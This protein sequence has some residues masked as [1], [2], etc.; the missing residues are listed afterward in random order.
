MVAGV[1]KETAQPV[2]H[3]QETISTPISSAC[4]CRATRPRLLLTTECLTKE[5][6]SFRSRSRLAALAAKLRETL[7]GA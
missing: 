4:S 1:P 5:F 7:D 2:I 6:I 3:G